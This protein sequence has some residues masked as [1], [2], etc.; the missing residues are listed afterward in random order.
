MS[1]SKGKLAFLFCLIGLS[2][3]NRGTNSRKLQENASLGVVDSESHRPETGGPVL[4]VTDV[5]VSIECPEVDP[6]GSIGSNPREASVAQEEL[7]RVEGNPRD[8]F[9]ESV[10][11]NQADLQ[12][13]LRLKV[14]ELECEFERL[15]REKGDKDKARLEDLRAKDKAQLED[16]RAKDRAQ[17]EGLRAKDRAQ[18][19][20]L[21]AKVSRYKDE[22]D[23]FRTVVM[24]HASDRT[25]PIYEAAIRLNDRE[26]DAQIRLLRKTEELN[27]SSRS[28]SQSVHQLSQ[29][30]T[31]L[32]DEIAKAT[33]RSVDPSSDGLT[34]RIQELLKQKRAI[35][36]LFKVCVSLQVILFIAIRLITVIRRKES[37]PNVVSK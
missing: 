17:L 4:V 2:I 16:L 14:M 18:L 27:N 37:V 11:L 21:R 12:E 34:S 5:Q 31:R 8:E 35:T 1:L 19:E 3:G 25:E 36:D 7:Q 9:K 30:I 28:F 15:Y 22:I 29:V 20:D 13:R 32:N 33:N 23:R 10:R 26:R 6:S 24:E